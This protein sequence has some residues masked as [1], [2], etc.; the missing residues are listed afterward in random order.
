MVIGVV[1]DNKFNMQQHGL[2]DNACAN[3]AYFKQKSFSDGRMFCGDTDTFLRYIG[4]LNHEMQKW[5]FYNQ[6][7]MV[8]P[9]FP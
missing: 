9:S 7:Q 2:N 6:Q 5:I 3:F 1:Q 8:I 4:T